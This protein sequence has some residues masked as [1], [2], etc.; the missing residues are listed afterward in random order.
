[1]LRKSQAWSLDIMLAVVIF[2]GTIF[3]FYII[4]NSSQ[5]NKASELEDEASIVIQG[6]I[7]EDSEFG[8]T[9]G[10]EIDIDKLEEL[11]GMDY[12]E[13]K[14]KLRVQNEFCIFFEDNDG[15]VIYINTDYTGIGS[16]EISVSDVPCA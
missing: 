4:L 12:S 6:V 14:T 2:L 8:I 11:L 7:S 9:D 3:F 1:M 16:S 15:N 13:I 10:N 5:G